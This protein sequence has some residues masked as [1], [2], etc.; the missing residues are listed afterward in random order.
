MLTEVSVTVQN[1][2]FKENAR[3]VIDELIASGVR[4][5][6]VSS[7][8]RRH[9]PWND[10]IMSKFDIIV[11]E[12]DTQFHKPDPGV[13]DRVFEKWKDIDRKDIF[14]VGDVLTD[15]EAAKNAD[16]NFICFF[17]E[18][19]HKEED[20]ISAGVDKASIIRNLNQIPRFIS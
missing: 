14:Y 6:L 2:E 20:F 13:F 9:F 11:T 1:P 10:P 5:A 17:N 15:F 7:R 12:Q 4:L 3:E 8:D 16:I 19:I 18:K